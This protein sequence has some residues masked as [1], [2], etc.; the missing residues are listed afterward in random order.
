MD[1]K[2]LT[3]GT[4]LYLPVP[5]PGALF[6][7]AATHPAMGDTEVCGTAVESAMTIIVRLSTIKQHAIPYPQ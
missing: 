4:A 3:A 5:A 6:S 2:H 1:I 7:V